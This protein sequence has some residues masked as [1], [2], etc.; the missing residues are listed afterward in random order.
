MTKKTSTALIRIKPREVNIT[1]THTDENGKGFDIFHSYEHNKIFLIDS[2]GDVYYID[3]Y[4]YE[5]SDRNHMQWKK[6]DKNKKIIDSYFIGI[7]DEHDIIE[8]K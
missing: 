8:D 7:P 3:E 1:D 5:W 6:W 2:L 4:D